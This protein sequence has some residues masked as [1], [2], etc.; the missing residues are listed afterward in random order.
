M[1]IATNGIDTN[2][3]ISGQRSAPTVVLSHVIGSSL[4]MWNAQMDVLDERYRVVRYDTRGLGLSSAPPPPYS[5]DM[6]V[7]DA[8]AL[9][10]ALELDEVHWAGLSLGAMIGLGLAIDHPERLRSLILCDCMATVSEQ[11][12][13]IWKDRLAAQDM[14]SMVD[15]AVA[16]W[17]TEPY[18]ESRAEGYLEN[19]RQFLA[20]QLDGYLGNCHAIMN[21]HYM[22]RLHRIATPTH[23][24]VGE[25]DQATPVAAS[26]AIRDRIAGSTMTVI[27][28][29]AHL[30][31]VEKADVFNEALLGFLDRH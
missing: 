7:A 20:S 26:I 5:M 16:R 21:M 15:G 24:I 17:F 9:L 11:S 30:C 14:A 22:D 25:L 28:G 13:H 3:E 27:E 1:M 18:R 10:D 6:L 29:G 8:V 12:M 2:C 23:L 31:N 19:R 4:V